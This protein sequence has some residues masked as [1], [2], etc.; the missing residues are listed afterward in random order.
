MNI[1]KVDKVENWGKFTNYF[2]EDII[3]PTII[4]ILSLI[5]LILFC[6][7]VKYG[8]SCPTM[9]LKDTTKFFKD[10]I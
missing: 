10:N 3:I 5:A 4:S 1:Y 8:F 7:T 2:A 6:Y 9:L